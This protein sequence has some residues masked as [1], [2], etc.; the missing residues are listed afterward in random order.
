MTLRGWYEGVV[1][2]EIGEQQQQMLEECCLNLVKGLL[3]SWRLWAEACA[4]FN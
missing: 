4:E 1:V 2:V 3:I